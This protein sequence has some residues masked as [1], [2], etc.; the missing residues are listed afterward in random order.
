VRSRARW[1]LDPATIC[2]VNEDG[3]F[4]I[5]I[6]G[7]VELMTVLRSEVSADGTVKREEYDEEEII[8]P[9]NWIGVTPAEVSFDDARQW[10]DVFKQISLDGRSFTWTDFYETFSSLGYSSAPDMVRPLWDQG[11]HKLFKVS[12]MEAESLV[13]NE[14]MAY[15]SLERQSDPVKKLAMVRYLVD[16]YPKFAPGWQE[17]ANLLESDPDRLAAIESGL[18]AEP[19]AETRGMLLINK[20]LILDRQ[21]HH[22]EAVKLLG[23]L[24][25]DPKSTVGTE[26]LAKATLVIIAKP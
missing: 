2:R 4:N 5:E 20:A 18:A 8:Q 3:T 19:D 22:D 16:Q 7:R 10:P 6:A 1:A 24:A 26:Q 13:L 25:I 14:A 9:S 11:C 23:Q 17:L 21:G 15:L 12:E